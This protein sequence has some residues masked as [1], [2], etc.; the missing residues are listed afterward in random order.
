MRSQSVGKTSRQSSRHS[1]MAS[2]SQAREGGRLDLIARGADERVEVFDPFAAARP[3]RSLLFFVFHRKVEMPH[4][5]D[6]LASTSLISDALPK[7][8]S[9]FPLGKRQMSPLVLREGLGV[10]LPDP[11]ERTRPVVDLHTRVLGSCTEPYRRYR[12]WRSTS[13]RQESSSPRA[14]TRTGSSQAQKSSRCPP[15]QPTT[16]WSQ[17]RGPALPPFR[18][19]R[20][21]IRRCRPIRCSRASSRCRSHWPRANHPGMSKRWFRRSGRAPS[22]PALLRLHATCYPRRACRWAARSSRGGARECRCARSPRRGR[23]EL[24]SPRLTRSSS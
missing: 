1:S 2:S 20:S 19:C 16:A 23:S 24:Q 22:R 15:C 10:V 3:R 17:M 11:R 18:W 6:P 9:V 4:G 21:C 8:W 5:L 7:L 14:A 12:G 13:C